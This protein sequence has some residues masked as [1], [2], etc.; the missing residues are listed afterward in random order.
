MASTQAPCTRQLETLADLLVGSERAVSKAT[1]ATESDG[2]LEKLD[3]HGITLLVHERN[4]LPSTLHRQLEQRKAMMAANELLKTRALAELFAA[5]ESAGL[6]R[7]ILFKGSA[8]AYSCYPQPWLRPRSDSDCLIDKSQLDQFTKVFDQLGYQKL[9]AIDAEH[10]HYQ[11]TFG[12]ALAGQ[13][14][15]NIDLHWHISNRKI[16][17]RAFDVENL[18][19]QAH[20][21]PAVAPQ[22]KIPCPVDSILIA[23]VHRLG[24]HPNEERLVWL[25]DIHLLS[26]S[27]SASEWQSLVEKAVSKQLAALSLDALRLCQQLFATPVAQQV[28]NQLQLAAATSEPSQL[29][30]DRNLSEWHYFWRDLAGLDG[31]NK[32]IQAV[33]ESLFPSADYVR[34]QMNSRWTAV[35]YCK[36]LLRGIRRLTGY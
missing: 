17:A 7:I 30:L 33:W 27:L 12:K 19:L 34:R 16:L 14:T 13:S 8:L 2:L 22:I 3:Y 35:A 31:F 15:I 20:P 4:L 26:Q 6:D 32:K 29:F 1:A 24:H 9:F 21:L 23:A 5:F 18:L 28:I 10:I 25:Y 11:A 36:R